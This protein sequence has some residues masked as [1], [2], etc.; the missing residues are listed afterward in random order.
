MATL[1][2]ANQTKLQDAIDL[3]LKGTARETPISEDV[4]ERVAPV[5]ANLGAATVGGVYELF[6]DHP[7]VSL[8][9]TVLS[10]GGNQLTQS[11]LN[12]TLDALYLMYKGQAYETPFAEDVINRLSPIADATGFL[13]RGGFQEAIRDRPVST[14]LRWALFLGKK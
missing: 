14:M 4:I 1:S 10:C 9:G 13:T 5:L 8:I 2:T 6:R 11:N 7:V 12:R 3:L